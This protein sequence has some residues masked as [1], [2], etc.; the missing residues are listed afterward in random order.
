MDTIYDP[1]RKG[2]FSAIPE[3]IVR[4]KLIKMMIGP[5]G[6]PKGLIS[7][8]KNISELPHVL[9]DFSAKRRADILCFAKN[10]HKEN[11]LHPLLMIECK[12]KSFNKSVEEQVIG[13]NHYVNA[14]FLC[15]ANHDKIKTMWYDKKQ[16]KYLS[17][18]FLPSYIEL[19]NAVKN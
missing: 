7:V 9:K 18:D 13:Y 19:L 16:N 10:I 8:E 17:V 5:L 2:F 3:E 15:I 4:Q 14:F 11:E 1:I 12:A 6:Y